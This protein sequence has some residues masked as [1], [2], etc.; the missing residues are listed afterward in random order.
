MSRP[1]MVSAPAR[2]WGREELGQAGAEPAPLTWVQVSVRGWGPRPSGRL[3]DSLPAAS[4]RGDEAAEGDQVRAGP[5]L[6]LQRPPRRRCLPAP[7]LPQRWWSWAPRC[8]AAA[9]KGPGLA[10]ARPAC[11]TAGKELGGWVGVAAYTSPPIPLARLSFPVWLLSCAHPTSSPQPQTCS[12][13]QQRSAD[14]K[15]LIPPAAQAWPQPN[16]HRAPRPALRGRPWARA[17]GTGA[18]HRPP[19][20]FRSLPV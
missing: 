8:C 15:D 19:G 7:R 5:E 3:A 1:K 2:G 12:P 11:R 17:K 6:R 10:E 14:G 13:L 4:G 18:P 20:P 16:R 9:P